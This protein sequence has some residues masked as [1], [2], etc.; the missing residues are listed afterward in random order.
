MTLDEGGSAAIIGQYRPDTAFVV[1]G[2]NYATSHNRTSGDLKL[3]WKWRASMSNSASL[4]DQKDYKQVLAQVKFYMDQHH[5]RHAF[6][7]T[8]AKFVAVKRL[9]GNG[10][11]ALADAIP[12]TSGG[13]GQIWSC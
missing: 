3:S 8:N 7:L 4:S 11:L 2:G 6:I 12:R 5:A 13:V 1:V 10:R 9:D